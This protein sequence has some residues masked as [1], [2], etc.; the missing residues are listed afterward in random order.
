MTIFGVKM[1]IL[2]VQTMSASVI[3]VTQ[4]A[5]EFV[6]KVITDSSVYSFKQLLLLNHSTDFN[7]FSYTA[8]RTFHEK[9]MQLVGVT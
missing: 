7:Q 8:F 2:P 5:V 3:L 6:L 9:N 1:P 4:K